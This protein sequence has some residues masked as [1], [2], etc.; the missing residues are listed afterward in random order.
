MAL[1]EIRFTDMGLCSGLPSPYVQEPALLEPEEEDE[2]PLSCAELTRRE[3]QGLTINAAVAAIAAQYIYQIVIQRAL[4]S[5]ASW[6][7]P[8]PPSATSVL[9]TEDNIGKI[10]ATLLNSLTSRNA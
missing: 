10:R 3:E 4:L 1:D 2:T 8:I 9:I 5:F 6:I 7:N